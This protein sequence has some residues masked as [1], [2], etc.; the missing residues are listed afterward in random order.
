ME[1]KVF[2]ESKTAK[3]YYDTLLDALFLEYTN[4]VIDDGEFIK[5]NTAALEAFKQLNT[6]KFVADI[7]KMGVISVSS[8][9][10]IV[11][12]LIPGLIAHLKGKPLFHAQ[13]LD[14]AEIF[15]R[16]SAKNIK[17]KSAQEIKEFN[18][19]QFSDRVE[20]EKYLYSINSLLGKALAG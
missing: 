2:F 10:W 8:Q 15:S 16:I 19:E 4:K 5:I 13:F 3:I 9:Q 14:P 1:L 20:L 6:Q 11:K 12:T 17:V 7:R 18:V